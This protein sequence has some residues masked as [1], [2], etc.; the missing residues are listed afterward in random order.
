[1]YISRLLPTK[2][3]ISCLIPQEQKK[4]CVCHRYLYFFYINFLQ[5]QHKS[6]LRYSLKTYQYYLSYIQTPTFYIEKQTQKYNDWTAYFD[7]IT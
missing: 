1:M 5:I 6:T 4:I 7:L 2:E 3:A